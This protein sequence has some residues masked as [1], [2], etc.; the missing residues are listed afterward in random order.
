MNA[1]KVLLG[2]AGLLSLSQTGCRN[3]TVYVFADGFEE[4]CDGAP[5][6]WTVQAGTT[7]TAV[8][9]ETLPGEHGVLIDGSPMAILRDMSGDELTVAVNSATVV[10]E[11]AARCEGS[12]TLTFEIGVESLASGEIQTFS[13]DFNPPS[14]WDGTLD[15][16]TLTSTGSG[17]GIL[18]RNIVA[19]RIVKSG[20]GACEIDYVALRDPG[21]GEG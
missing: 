4:V 3:D 20:E 7:G 2:L 10:A 1:K 5:C 19:L 17:F 16:R 21:T 8:Y 9:N 15:A 14:T 6:G 13:A 18:F 12:V 11:M